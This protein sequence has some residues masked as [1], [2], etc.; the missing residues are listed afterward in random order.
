MV[1]K[2]KPADSSSRLKK[3]WILATAISGAF[4]A[5][6][7]TYLVFHFSY[8]FYYPKTIE[9]VGILLFIIIICV[10]Y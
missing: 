5:A 3:Q 4:A 10:A 7:L 2:D 8:E 1:T 9:Y 6:G